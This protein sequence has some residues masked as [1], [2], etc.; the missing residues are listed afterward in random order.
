MDRFFSQFA[1]SA[2]PPVGRLV[3]IEGPPGCGKSETLKYLAGKY[4]LRIEF[5]NGFNMREMD[6]KIQSVN[7]R[8]IRKGIQFGGVRCADTPHV[9]VI[10]LLPEPATKR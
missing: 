9:L 10:E 6:E 1:T 7:Q 2:Y 4:Q 5:W 3:V 8:L